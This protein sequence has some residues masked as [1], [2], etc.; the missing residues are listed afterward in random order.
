MSFRRLRRS[1]RRVP[2]SDTRCGCVFRCRFFFQAED[3]IRDGHV[4]EFRRVLFRSRA[5]QYVYA[6]GQRTWLV[7]GTLCYTR[8]F[9]ESNRFAN[10]NVGEDARFVWSARSGRMTKLA[11]AT[12]RSEERRVGKERGCGAMAVRL[13]ET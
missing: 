7:G 9:W 5:W 13:E 10:I 8:A 3:G 2:L 11:D 6:N 12:F 1:S 4:T